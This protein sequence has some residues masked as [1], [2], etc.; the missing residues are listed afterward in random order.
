MEKV[1][2]YAHVGRGKNK[3]EQVD[4]LL[5]AGVCQEN[6]IIDAKAKKKNKCNHQDYYRL[7]GSGDLVALLRKGD[8]LIIT[9]FS[10]LGANYDEIIEQWL[11]ITKT[12]QADIQ[13]LDMPA[14]NL[15]NICAGE[16][17]NAANDL[18]VQMLTYARDN[19]NAKKCFWCKLTKK[20]F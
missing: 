11:I 17:K 4:R 2:G 1:F 20:K 12:L 7:I 9:D 15:R 8:L 13:V 6:I 19:A 10:V 16:C 3:N 18:F 14:L 5:E